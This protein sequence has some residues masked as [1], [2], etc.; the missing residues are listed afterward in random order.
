MVELEGN[1]D[2]TSHVNVPCCSVFSHLLN[3][4]TILGAPFKKFASMREEWALRNHYRNPGR[5]QLHPA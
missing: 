4:I 2:F 5:E 1:A 3:Y